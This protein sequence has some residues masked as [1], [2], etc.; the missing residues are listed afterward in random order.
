MKEWTGLQIRP[1]ATLLKFR[2]GWHSLLD[3]VRQ[4]AEQKALGLFAQWRG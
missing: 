3:A 1:K 4:R 2:A